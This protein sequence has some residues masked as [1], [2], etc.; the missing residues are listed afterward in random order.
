M[1]NKHKQEQEMKTTYIKPVTK[2]ISIDEQLMRATSWTDPDGK[3]HKIDEGTLTGP[4]T[5]D[6]AKHFSFPSWSWEEE[7]N[8]YEE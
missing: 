8:D 7:E 4:D 1:R 3:T 6:E 5:P 2:V